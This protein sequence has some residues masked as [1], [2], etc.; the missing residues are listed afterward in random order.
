MSKNF[1]LGVDKIVPSWFGVLHRD[2]NETRGVLHNALMTISA[3]GESLMGQYSMPGKH[4]T[5]RVDLEKKADY[6]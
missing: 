4:E 5:P 3:A 6:T 1:Q 2:E